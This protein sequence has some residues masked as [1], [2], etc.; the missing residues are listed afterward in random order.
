[1][2]ASGDTGV[3]PSGWQRV[4]GM[5]SSGFVASP[6]RP[7]SVDMERS[8]AT[9]VGQNAPEQ[10]VETIGGIV[11]GAA[12]SRLPVVSSLEA[13]H[14]PQLNCGRPNSGGSFQSNPT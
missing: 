9:E 12:R 11:H 4:G 10:D 7:G 14:E 3:S 1:M 8:G 5:T 2:S 6:Q 13:G